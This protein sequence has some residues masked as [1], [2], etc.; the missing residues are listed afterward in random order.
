MEINKWIECSAAAA[1]AIATADAFG[2]PLP[3]AIEKIR[4]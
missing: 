1:A 2:C 3:A 4:R